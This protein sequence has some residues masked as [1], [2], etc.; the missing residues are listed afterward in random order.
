MSAE[1]I[2]GLS[3][4]HH[5]SSVALLSEHGEILF[6][7][8]EEWLSRVKNDHRFPELAIEEMFRLY[9]RDRVAAIGHFQ[10]PLRN[11]LGVGFDKGLSGANYSTKVKQLHSS[12]LSYAHKLSKHVGVNAPSYFCPHHMSHVLGAMVCARRIDGLEEGGRYYTL[13]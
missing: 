9:P 6:Y 1:L 13:Y 3:F 12:D 8:R 4:G 10:K 11:W 5:E 2:V 7:C